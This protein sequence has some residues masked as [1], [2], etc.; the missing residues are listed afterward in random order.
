MNILL[1]K[2]TKGRYICTHLTVIIQNSLPKSHRCVLVLVMKVHLCTQN[3][4]AYDH[5]RTAFKS[6]EVELMKNQ[7]P[8]KWLFASSSR[9]LVLKGQQVPDE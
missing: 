9:Y 2:Q 8:N 1:K 6:N 7:L 5:N 4:K 3:G